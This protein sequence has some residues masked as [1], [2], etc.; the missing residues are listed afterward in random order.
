MRRQVWIG[1]FLLSLISGDWACGEGPFCCEPDAPHFQARF[2]PAGGW[3]PYGGG[4]VHWWPKHCFPRDGLPD[5]YCRKPIPK[6]CWPE[7]PPYFFTAQRQAPIPAVV[8]P[9]DLGLRGQR[10]DRSCWPAR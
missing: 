7:Y 10:W 1:A 9:L 4:L 5:D 3:F 8:V 6:V 2:A